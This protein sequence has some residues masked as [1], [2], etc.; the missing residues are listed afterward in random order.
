MRNEL[1]YSVLD[2]IK[3]MTGEEVTERIS[4]K[5]IDSNS[6]DIEILDYIM[7]FISERLTS[8]RSV[9]KGGYVLMRVLP[10]KARY[11]HDID[12]SI[13]DEKQYELVKNVL[14]ELGEDLLSKNIIIN[15]T[16]KDTIAPTKSGGIK[17]NR[18][19]DKSDLGIDIGLHDLSYGISRWN[20]GIVDTE[21]FT[22]ERM[23]S[24]KLSVIY[25]RKRFRRA[26]DLYDFYIL[27]NSTDINVELLADYLSKRGISWTDTPFNEVVIREYRKAYDK[28]DIKNHLNILIG[29]PEFDE[30]IRTLHNYV[31]KIR[32]VMK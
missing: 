29:K 30:C 4:I 11:S 21:R 14:H 24:D 27:V 25:S 16:V 28:L 31:I 2:A 19:I 32:E 18:G 9:F 6:T 22:V 17:L 5:T 8:V 13:S 15:Y 12:F 7:V 23:L 3:K 26:K 1:E 20:I 10:E